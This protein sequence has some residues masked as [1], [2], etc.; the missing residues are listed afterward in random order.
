MLLL[1]VEI[2]MEVP[3]EEALLSY[4]IVP[5]LPHDEV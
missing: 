4:L 2:L 1:V 5:L 3:M